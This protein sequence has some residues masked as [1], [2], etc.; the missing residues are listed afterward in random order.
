M[1][2]SRRRGGGPPCRRRAVG[3]EVRRAVAVS[4]PILRPALTS[5]EAGSGWGPLRWRGGEGDGLPRST[6]AG[7]RCSAS[8][9]TRA[10]SPAVAA[11]PP[12]WSLALPWCR[13]PADPDG[14]EMGDLEAGP[15]E[16][17]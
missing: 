8:P 12:P 6:S 5:S 11:P 1:S 9:G 16:L 13:A 17:W 15:L 7:G 10:A 3:E 2:S 4:G 14:V